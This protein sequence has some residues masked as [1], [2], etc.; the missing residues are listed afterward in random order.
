MKAGIVSILLLLFT[1]SHGL[2]RGKDY[3][4]EKVCNEYNRL[5][6]KNFHSLSIVMN[7]RKYSNATIDQ[8]MNL[9]NEMVHLAEKCCAAGADPDCYN[10]EASALSNKS[11]SPDAPFPKH[12]GIAGCCTEE[13]LARKLCLAALRHPPKE[14]PTYVEPSNEEIC[15]TFKKD[16]QGFEERFLV[17]YSSDYS[18]APLPVLLNSTW[19]YLSIVRTCCASTQRITCFLKERLQQ[20]PIQALTHL[21]NKACSVYT[22]LGKNKTKVSY[23]IRFTQ[24]SPSLPF[25][26]AIAL[27]GEASE[28]LSKC[29][30]SSEENCIQN[31]IVVHIANI[32][33]TVCARNERIKTCCTAKDDVGKYLCIYSLPWDKHP[34]VPQAPSSIDEGLCRAGGEADIY[35]YISDMARQYT[36]APEALLVTLY[37]ASQAAT[38]D[39]CGQPD[40]QSCFT[41]KNSQ[42]IAP[43]QPLI[44]KGNELCAEYS[45]HNVQE[46]LK[47]LKE[48]TI[49]LIPPGT[50]NTEDYLSALVEQKINYVSKCCHLNAPPAYCGMQVAGFISNSAVQLKGRRFS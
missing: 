44:V 35:R 22:L 7:S 30:A 19:S 43:L 4:K 47:R 26:N 12:P 14:F 34:Q 48:N 41:E 20:K 38:N 10:N 28:I 13:G 31:E 8:I 37:E 11:C 23:L 16:P 3:F 46:F 33:N 17:E 1:C 25:E 15:D 42:T 39:C 45:D 29:C 5:G 40:P 21:S 2:E 32:C 27:A 24:Q 36:R 6:K 18:Y 49:P 50:L 9:V